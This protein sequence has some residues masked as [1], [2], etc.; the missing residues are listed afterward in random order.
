[1][2]TSRLDKFLEDSVISQALDMDARGE[3][4][5]WLALAR[6]Q[7]LLTVRIGQEFALE[8]LAAERDA[9]DQMIALSQDFL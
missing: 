2:T 7:S 3:T 1:M 9:D 6:R 4:I 5:D 8:M